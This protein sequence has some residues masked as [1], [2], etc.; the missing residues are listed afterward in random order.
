MFEIGTSLREARLRQGIELSE[1]EEG[2]KIRNKYLRALED[3]RFEVLPAHT[4]VKG[5]LRSYADFLGL[6]G[7][8]YVDEYNSRYVTGEDEQAPAPVR[9]RPRSRAERRVESRVVV[10]T[11]AG[12]AGLTALIFAAWNATPERPRIPNLGTTPATTPAGVVQTPEERAAPVRREPGLTRVRLVVVASRGE[13]WLRV[14][15][16]SPNGPIVDELTLARGQRG[17]Y[18]VDKRR[19]LFLTLGAPGN[20]DIRVNG[21]RQGFSR[22]P[23]ASLAVTTAGIARV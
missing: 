13:C 8:L 20:V 14:R 23:G 15:K 21:K 6:D 16:G 10:L 2:T 12:I 1:A 19:R 9:R 4:Y 3:E 11:L 7:Q 18:T 17:I 22:T 5:F